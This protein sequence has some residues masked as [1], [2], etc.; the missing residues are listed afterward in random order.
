MSADAIAPRGTRPRVRSRAGTLLATLL[1]TALLMT[2][3][4]P[5]AHAATGSISGTI[6]LP[7]GTEPAGG[8]VYLDRFDAATGRWTAED[9]SASVSM[10]G[11]FTIPDVETGIDFRIYFSTYE[12]SLLPGYYAGPGKA[13]VGDVMDAVSVRAGATGVDLRFETGVP[14]RGT[15]DIF[16]EFSD[17]RVE[18]MMQEFPKEGG[19][20]LGRFYSVYHYVRSGDTWESP[21]V[22]PG[23]QYWLSVRTVGFQD[24]FR[25]GYY[26][27]LTDGLV[28][29]KEWGTPVTSSDSPHLVV[30]RGNVAARLGAVQAPE[31]RGN[32]QVGSRLTAS[33][34]SWS[35]YGVR[36]SYQWLRDGA[37]IPGATA[38][39]YTAQ[40]ADLGSRLA[41]LVTGKRSGFMP[42]TATSATTKPVAKGAAPRAS[43][44][45]AVTG[46]ARLGSTLNASTGTWSASGT[47]FTYQWLR[48]GKTITGATSSRYKA[49]TA[50]VGKRVSVHVT[51]RIAGREDGIASSSATKVAKGKPKVTVKA[52]KKVKAGKRAKLVVRVKA[53]GLARPTGKVIVKYGKKSIKAKLVAKRKGKVVVRLPKLAKGKYKITV[54]YKPNAKSKNFVTK[55]TSK[56]LTLRVR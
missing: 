50:D 14:L 47:S 30:K 40:P 51:A 5:A 36:T 15:I 27:A 9:Y 7:A 8:T 29:N 56:A 43:K 39:S 45:P 4:A 34:G 38:S 37:P 3:L 20:H 12:D 22:R 18:I 32:P 48:D 24:I 52:K 46:A 11:S 55:S 21:Y 31:V 16:D 35:L 28:G 49:T 17:S 53:A 23:A 41:V 13:L 1:A 44:A 42:A 2:G 10:P 54:T 6:T 33:P 26:N 19:G 25:Q